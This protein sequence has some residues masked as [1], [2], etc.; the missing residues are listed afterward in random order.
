M[1]HQ[2]SPIEEVTSEDIRL[3]WQEGKNVPLW[4]RLRL[5]ADHFGVS[6]A[7]VVA[8][9]C[10][11]G[12]ARLCG[13]W[14]DLLLSLQRNRLLDLAVGQGNSVMRVT[15]MLDTLSV[16]NEKIWLEENA[17]GMTVDA[18]RIQSGFAALEHDHSGQRDVF[19]FFDLQGEP[20][21]IIYASAGNQRLYHSLLPGFIHPV[22]KSSQKIVLSIKKA[23]VSE[24]LPLD[25]DH[26]KLQW[27]ILRDWKD[28][29]GL[30]HH[31]GISYDMVLHRLGQPLARR[32]PP[33]SL[34]L[35]LE[36]GDDHML[37][38]WF[39]LR[40]AGSTLSWEGDVT[41]KSTSTCRINVDG[42]GLQMDLDEGEIDHAWLVEL[43]G[44]KLPP[45]VEF[46]GARGRH[47]LSLSIHPRSER[48]NQRTWREILEA[49]AS[50][51][52]F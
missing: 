29:P 33:G 45:L 37:P 10:G 48:Q 20:V 42:N 22:Q 2:I 36:V 19:Y 3:A 39:C 1:D 35:L 47:L 26:L 17:C 7:E 23:F 28:I 34:R 6:P 40:G 31:Y 18:R 12:V 13:D 32:V 50:S 4:A 24:E 41:V 5:V 46:F 38:F 51:E 52:W 21:L 27:A 16:L 30:I 11:K 8:S 44:S 43:P 14:R 49:L 25:F 15:T 9:G